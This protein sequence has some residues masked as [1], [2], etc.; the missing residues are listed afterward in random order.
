MA[1]ND[2]SNG[3]FESVL[4]KPETTG[5]ETVFNGGEFSGAH[6]DS[7]VGEEVLFGGA[8]VSKAGEEL[9]YVEP[10][11]SGYSEENSEV[12]FDTVRNV[13]EE[14]IEPVM[15]V[16]SESGDFVGAETVF[17][18]G[19]EDLEDITEAKIEE[20]NFDFIEPV[21]P[22]TVDEEVLFGGASE[23]EKVEEPVAVDFGKL[24]DDDL[25]GDLGAYAP[26]NKKSYIDKTFAYK[27][28][29]ADD[30]LVGFYKSVRDEI[31]K[32]KHV[33]AR[34]SN[35]YESFN[36]GRLQLFKIGLAGKTVKLYL[37]LPITE[38][39]GKMHC[40]DMSG[41]K[42]YAEVPTL[43]K[44]RSAR[45]VGYAKTLIEKTANRYALKLNK[46]TVDTSNVIELLQQYNE[47]HVSK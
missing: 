1:L 16:K 15:P 26:E 28:L 10:Q 7:Q 21:K 14:Y 8:G 41:V 12:L 45:A 13:R 46:K 36:S 22:N 44:I 39:E 47:K 2:K 4:F 30:A 37:N 32:Y 33:K 40:K 5:S 31:L 42:S 43:L 18:S 20:E 6:G 19:V 3:V 35:N 17:S 11:K 27:M 25:I 9:D 34:Y 38:T 29:E 24:S 23:P